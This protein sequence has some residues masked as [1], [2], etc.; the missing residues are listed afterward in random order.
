MS[1]L[2]EKMRAARR[3]E[4]K[5]GDATFFGTRA[6]PEEFSRYAT[7]E[8]TD[9]EAC[10]RHIDGWDG[11]KESDLVEGGSDDLIKFN[12]DDFSEAISEKPEW[13][14]PIVAKIL[15]DAQERFLHRAEN[16]KK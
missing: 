15:E 3:I 6:T 11:V 14:K 13:Y 9:S 2:A 7:Q 1:G 10:R 12:K 8:I 4:V 16:E 5:V